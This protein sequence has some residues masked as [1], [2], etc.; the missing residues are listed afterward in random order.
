[1][2][3]VTWKVY[4]LGRMAR[5]MAVYSDGRCIPEDTLDSFETL[6]LAYCELLFLVTTA[7]LST[8]QREACGLVCSAITAF[9]TVRE[10][11]TRSRYTQS[12]NAVLIDS[13][14]VGQ[15]SF[16]IPYSQLSFLIE[17]Q[18]TTLQVAEIR[19]TLVQ[20]IQK[21]KISEYMGYQSETSFL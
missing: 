21:I 6:E 20:T 12:F 4:L 16:T 18:F 7:Q 2:A 5:D 1:M 17:N 3:D 10:E 13:G 14:S 19:G 15:P 11:S 8:P 9:H